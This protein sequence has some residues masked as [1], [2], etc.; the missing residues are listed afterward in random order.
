M[1]DLAK[2]LHD[3]G[4]ASDDNFELRWQVSVRR[5]HVLEQMCKYLHRR[6]LEVGYGWQS[7]GT[8]LQAEELSK[9]NAIEPIK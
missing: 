2:Y 4:E 9:L 1:R 6:I 3:Y 7:L 5:K 8:E